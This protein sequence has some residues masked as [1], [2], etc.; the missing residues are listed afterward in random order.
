MR[1]E[2]QELQICTGGALN[3]GKLIQMNSTF[4]QILGKFRKNR[5]SEYLKDFENLKEKK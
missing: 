1:P 3:I 2:H 4:L 5:M